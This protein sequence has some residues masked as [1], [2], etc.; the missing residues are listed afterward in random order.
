[1]NLQRY[2][3]DVANARRQELIPFVYYHTKGQVQTGPFAGMTIVPNFMWGDADVCGKLLGVYEDELHANIERAIELDPDLVINVGSAEGYYAVGMARRCSQARVIS[4]DLE[5]AAQQISVLNAGVNGVTNLV[6]HGGVDPVMLSQLLVEGQRPLIIS[7]CEGYE[8][9]LLDPA[10]VPDLDRCM[11][12]VE[13]HDC[14]D[15]GITDRIAQRFSGTHH[16]TRIEQ[17]GKDPYRF[18]FLRTVSDCDKWCLVH[19][20]R[21]ETGYWL[22]ME[23]V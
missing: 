16:I 10:T 21:P 4:A 20:G 18:E 8:N 19:E 12:L 13:T 22:W 5:S 1:M 15:A 9:V 3:Y 7:D 17:Q 23:P 14:L 11:I 2:L 6:P